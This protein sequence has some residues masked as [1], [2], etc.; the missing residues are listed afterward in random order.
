MAKPLRSFALFLV[1]LLVLTLACSALG[2]PVVEAPPADG[3]NVLFSDDFSDPDSGWDRV[4]A[5]EGLTDY[6]NG[7]Y[8]IFVDQAR[9]DRWAN[10]GL[11]FTDVQ[12]EADATKIGGPDD[13]DFGLV[14]RYQDIENFYAFLISSDGFYAILKYSGGSSEILG[15]DSWPPSEAINQGA[16]TNHLRADCIADSL[17]LYANGEQ[18][19]AVTDSAFSSGDVG[20]IAGTFDEPGADIAFDDFVVLQP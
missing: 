8:R 7:Q 18:L 19:H 1:P 2:G 3:T 11:S 9:F 17:T 6:D 20:L 15:S 12:V 13:N 16:A 14:C 5:D 10:P 4:Q